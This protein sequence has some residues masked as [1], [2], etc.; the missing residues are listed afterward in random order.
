MA[1]AAEDY[2]DQ[3]AVTFDLEPDHGLLAPTTR[4]AWRRLLL[5]HL[6]PA[7]A[8]V[9]DLGCGT[10]TLSVLLAQEGYR[11]QGLDSAGRMVEAA[12]R[13]AAAAGVRADFR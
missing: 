9:V 6:P 8:D 5:E 4:A 13:K 1:R 3:Q 12:R 10:G 7:P 11:V 2:W